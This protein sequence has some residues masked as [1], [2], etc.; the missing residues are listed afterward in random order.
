MDREDWWAT[1]HGVTKIWTGLGNS[2][3][4]QQSFK[5]KISHHQR[6][7]IRLYNFSHMSREV[8]FL[9]CNPMVFAE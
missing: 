4:K 3:T 6:N 2:T 1:V 5:E 7:V 9:L 8:I